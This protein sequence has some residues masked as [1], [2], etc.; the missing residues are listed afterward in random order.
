MVTVAVSVHASWYKLNTL[1]L[2]CPL[3]AVV[4]HGICREH[5]S[6]QHQLHKIRQNVTIGYQLY[7]D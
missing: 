7:F 1:H 2:Y 5:K 4:T 6:T 3:S